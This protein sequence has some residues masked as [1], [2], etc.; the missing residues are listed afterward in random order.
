[1]E[2]WICSRRWD[3]DQ[4]TEPDWQALN[5]ETNIWRNIKKSFLLKIYKLFNKNAIKVIKPKI[6]DP[7]NYFFW[8]GPPPLQWLNRSKP[9]ILDE[10]NEGDWDEE[11]DKVDSI[12]QVFKRFA[13]VVTQDLKFK[14][15]IKLQ[16]LTLNRI[17]DYDINWLMWSNLSRLTLP[18]LLFHTWCMF[19]PIC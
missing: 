5:R 3:Q 19:E 11:S 7:L 9:K 14:K 12:I 2:C 6:G 8:K 15:K 1:M 4:Q 16:L 18:T 10:T 13:A 17:T